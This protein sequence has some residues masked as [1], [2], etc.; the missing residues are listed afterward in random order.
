MFKKVLCIGNLSVLFRYR[1]YFNLS[2]LSRQRIGLQSMMGVYVVL[3][4]GMV[5]AFV[6]LFV[7]RYWHKKEIKKSILNKVVIR[8][9][10]M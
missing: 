2:A 6:T 4:S 9:V 1:L 7:E 10:I 8:F 5:I 3:I